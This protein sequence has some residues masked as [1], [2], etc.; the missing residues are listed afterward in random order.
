M[1]TNGKGIFQKIPVAHLRYAD[2]IT[3][4]C[5]WTPEHHS[6]GHGVDL[7][8]NGHLHQQPRKQRV[9]DLPQ[10]QPGCLGN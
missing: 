3:T 4:H 1:Q 5:R 6:W 9:N 7:H 2:L 10:S 8:P